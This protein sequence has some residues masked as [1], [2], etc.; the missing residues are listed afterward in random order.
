MALTVTPDLTLISDC[1]S[2]AGWLPEP[3]LDSDFKIQGAGCLA[4]QVKATLSSIHAYT[5]GS[6][7]DM[8]GKHIYVWM[9][10]AGV[11]DTKANGG[12]RIY[13]ETD[14]DNYG[15]WYVGGGDVLPA[16]SHPGGWG[17]YVIDPA[18]TPTS[19]MG[20]VNP[21]SITKI[22]VQFKTLSSV[23]GQANNC[24]WDVCRYGSG[25][26]ITSGATDQID[27]EDIFN[28]DN[29]LA[30][31]Y[32]VVTKGSG[33]SYVVQGLLTF[34]GAGAENV[35]FVDK[36]QSIIFPTN[37]FVSSSFYGIKVRC[38]TGTTN[39]TLGERSG[40]AG[41][42]GC[43]LKA[44]TQTFSFDAS[45][46]DIDKVQIYGTTF[47]NAGV[48]NLPPHATNREVLNCSFETCDEVNVSTCVV[49]NCNFISADDEAVI[50]PSGNTHKITDSNFISCP[51]GV[52]IPNAGEYD[53]YALMFSG[54][55]IDVDNT[56]GGAVTVNKKDLS[57]PTTSSGETTIQGAVDLSIHCQDSKGVAIEGVRCYI[58][59][60]IDQTQLM[61]EI[62]D[63]NGDAIESYTGNTPMDINVHIRKNSTGDT[64]YYPIATVGEI[65]SAG[66]AMTAVLQED[67][68]AV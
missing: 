55:T 2:I 25:L 7:Q 30:N 53:F 33:D 6:A 59:K 34:G 40:A 66:F 43:L 38:G 19:G 9:M 56:S 17:C 60:Q 50:L 64:R 18:S 23:V 42:R 4:A 36:S 15:T 65:T 26:I 39:F 24:F 57:N 32:G 28:D 12:Y 5:F 22:G 1:D 8:T 45:D 54:C 14:A 62:T 44:G 41:I 21:A 51:N 63:V 67:L 37:S 31:K 27:L 35:D 58:E 3:D 52:R 16:A 46:D 29:L 48:I 11:A 61:N 20:T 13:V 68:V 10:I 49:K 47:N